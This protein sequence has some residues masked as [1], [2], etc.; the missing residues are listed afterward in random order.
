MQVT[1][2]PND[3]DT[4]VSLVVTALGNLHLVSWFHLPNP[5]HSNIKHLTRY[6][7]IHVRNISQTMNIINPGQL[8]VQPTT[9]HC[10]RL[11]HCTLT[12]HLIIDQLMLHTRNN[13]VTVN[14]HHTRKYKLLK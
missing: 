13:L 7:H 9:G 11:T 6:H 14:M 2:I 10:L 5:E 3:N 12:L 8:T 1:Y 4:A